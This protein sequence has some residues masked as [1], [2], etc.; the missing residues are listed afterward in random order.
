MYLSI[1]FRMNV[2]LEIL[3]STLSYRVRICLKEL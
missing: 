1:K 2:N 3:W